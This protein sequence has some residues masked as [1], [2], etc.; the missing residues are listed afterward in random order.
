MKTE[1]IKTK[2]DWHEYWFNIK[3]FII[4]KKES[5]KIHFNGDGLLGYVMETH[6]PKK[7]M[8]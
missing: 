5:V 8:R 6:K 4:G 1:K 2:E 3:P 7:G